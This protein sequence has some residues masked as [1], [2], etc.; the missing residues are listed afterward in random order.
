MQPQDQQG[1]QQQKPSTG[2][3]QQT[4][5]NKWARQ[6]DSGQ[7]QAGA[8]PQPQPQ[9]PAIE[10]PQDKTQPERS[11]AVQGQHDQWQS[12]PRNS[13]VNQP[14]E[15][16]EDRSKSFGESQV[17]RESAQQPGEGQKHGETGI[18]P[19]ENSFPNYKEDRLVQD[20]TPESYKH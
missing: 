9:A 4:N 8:I 18:I 2:Q 17:G 10:E 6:G 5:V 11:Q 3:P 12:T 1:K 13:Q 7:S 15:A 14:K 19:K 16:Q 20:E